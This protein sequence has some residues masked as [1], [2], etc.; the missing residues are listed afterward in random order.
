[1]EVFVGV[2]CRKNETL[3]FDFRL[4]PLILHFLTT[5]PAPRSCQISPLQA[6]SNC[7]CAK[8]CQRI[9][10]AFLSGILP[11]QA[12][13]NNLSAPSSFLQLYDY[14]PTPN[15]HFVF[16]Q[17]ARRCLQ[18]T[19]HGVLPK[20]AARQCHQ[21]II[22][23]IPEE[24]QIRNSKM[25]VVICS[26]NCADWYTIETLSNSTARKKPFSPTCLC[27]IYS[28][29]LTRSPGPYF[30]Q[31][32]PQPMTSADCNSSLWRQIQKRKVCQACSCRYP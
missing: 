22:V 3:F 21:L 5:Y 11:F 13:Q 25:K 10:A 24:D 12:R 23:E 26:R 2:F 30:C 31:T 9:K 19:Q 20:H 18:I 28:H 6:S 17:Y 14:Q 4:V 1:M 29:A 7:C 16:P 27:K 15:L 8:T 32:R